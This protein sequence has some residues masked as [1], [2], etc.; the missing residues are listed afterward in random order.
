MLGRFSDRRL[1]ACMGGGGPG[2][3]PA[4]GGGGGKG[5]R[6]GGGRGG[7]GGMGRY[8]RMDRV[9]DYLYGREY[10]GRGVRGDRSGSRSGGSEDSVLAVPEWLND[11]R[12]LFPRETVEVIER[13]ALERYGL[14]E[15]V[16]DEETLR[17]MEP[18]YELLKAVLSFQHLMAPKVLEVA[19]R[20]VRQVVEDLKRRLARDVRQAFWGR[21]N[22]RRRSPLK[23]ARN[24]DWHRTIRANLKYYDRE[25]R[26]L[27]VQSLYYWSR[28]AHHIPWHIIMAVDCSGSMMDSVIHSAIMAG[29]FKGLP[30]VRVSLV[31]FDTSVVDLTEHADDPTE[32]LMSVQLGGGTDIA[33]AIG[34]CEGL[35]ISPT[36][37]I[38][39]LVTDFFE[40]GPPEGL[41]AAVKRLREAGVR[42]L[43]LAALDAEANP[44]YDVPM[45]ERCAAA[46][47]EIAALTP[48]RLAEWMA[49]VIS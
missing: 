15:L 46:G 44:S 2:Q 12:E 22:R 30:A 4:G 33:G 17:K 20:L 45:A 34:Y 48:G 25:R 38:L 23:V 28:V 21:L 43:G 29:I 40:G 49:R 10:A 6:G 14:T 11:V 18:S 39:V 3:S 9:L 19:R 26:R 8:E 27:V 41:V 31:A 47:A 1:G 7:A 5:R 42:V 24:L 35:A 13:H 36:R 37:T 16:T 32:V